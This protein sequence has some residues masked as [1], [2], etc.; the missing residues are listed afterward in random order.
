MEQFIPL[1]AQA[2]IV[3]IFAWFVIQNNREWR[4]Y[5]SERNGKLEKSLDR[6]AAVLEKHNEK[7]DTIHTNQLIS[8]KTE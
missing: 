6:I 5:F 2:P 1:L 4:R 7:L 3:G 8:Q